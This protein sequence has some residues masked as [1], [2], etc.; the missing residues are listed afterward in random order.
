MIRKH[1]LFCARATCAIGLG[2]APLI[3]A[4]LLAGCSSDNSGDSTETQIA[5]GQARIVGLALTSESIANVNVT[6]TG[7]GL[8]SP[9]VV[10]LKKT[11]SQWDGEALKIPAATGY[12]FTLAASDTTGKTIYS[13]VAAGITVIKGQTVQVVIYGQQTTA[14]TPYS[15]AAPIVDSVV[16]SSAQVAPGGTIS[17]VATAHD[18]NSGDV[19]TYKWSAGAGTFSDASASNTSWTAPSKAGTYPLTLTVTDQQ[20]ATTSIQLQIVV[21]ADAG[22]GAIAVTAT[23]NTWPV[24]TNVSAVPNYLVKGAA[25]VLT[26]QASDADGDSLTYAWTSTCSGAFSSTQVSMPT[27]TLNSAATDSTCTLSVLVS[28]S[29][30]GTTTGSFALPVGKPFTGALPSISQALQTLTEVNATDSVT[31]SVQASDPQKLALTYAW[32]ATDGTFSSQTDTS[33]GSTITWAPPAA[34]A[35]SWSIT[36]T[37]QDSAG[38]STPYTFTVRPKSCFGTAPAATAPWKFAI[39]GDTQ[40]TATDDGKNPNSVA[41]DIINQLN[42]QFVAQGVKFVVALGDI[43][44]NGS[45]AA[46]DTRA[47]FTQALYNAGIG[48]FPLRGNHESSANAAAEFVRVFPQTRTGL[49]NATPTNAFVPHADDVNTLPVAVSGSPFTVGSS[50]SSPSTALAG[51]SYS[52]DYANSRFVLLDQFT[53]ANGSANSIPAQQSW[54]TTVLSGRPAGTHAFVFGHK[55]IITED[56]EDTLFGADPSKDPAGQDA[57]ITSLASNGVRYYM[58]GHDHMHN[59]AIVTTTD[60]VSARVQNVIVASDSSKFYTPATP[61]NDVTYNLPA[62]GHTRETPIAQELYT[63]GY[64][65][66]TINDGRAMVDYYAAAANPATGV[67]TTPLLNFN[68]RESFGYGLNGKQFVIAP[69]GSYT[70]VIDTYGGTTMQIL[71]GTNANPGVEGGNRKFSKT[72]DTAWSNAECGTAS[73]RLALSVT[74]TMGSGQTDAYALAMTYDPA[75]VN[76]AQ[77][78]NGGLGIATKDTSGNWVNAVDKNFGGTKTFVLGAYKAGYSVGTY[79]VDTTTNTA[80]AVINH[81]SDFAVTSF[82]GVGTVNGKILAINDFHG[83]ISAGKTVSGHP[84]GSAAV[85][86]SYLKSAMAGQE[87]NTVLVEAGDLIG[88]SPASSA[89]LQDEPTITFFNSFGNAN[90]ARSN[91]MDSKCNLVG[92]PGNHEFDEGVDELMR[93]LKGGNHAKGPFLENPWAGARFP[94][95]S[96]NIVKSDGT[97][98]FSPYVIKNIGGLRVAFVGATLKDTPSIVIPA[99]VTGLTFNNEADSIN[100]QVTALKAMGIHAIVAVIHNGGSQTSYAGATSSSSAAPTSDIVNLVGRLDGDVDIVITAHSHAFT[101]AYVKNAGGNLALVTQAY[102][103]G[104]GFANIDITLDPAT[105]D[106]TSKSATIVTTYADAAGLVPDPSMAALTSAAEALVGPIANTVIT[107][108]SGILTRTQ[109]SAGESPLGDMVAEAQRQ[110]VY[111]DFGITNPGGLRADLPVTCTTSPCSITWNDCFTS[112]PFGNVVMNVT[113]TGAQLYAVLEQQWAGQS[114]PK[115]LQIS[116]FGYSWSSSAPVGSKIVVGSLHKADG[117]PIDLS[118]SYT[119]AINNFLQGGGDGFTVFTGATRVVPGP[120]DLDALVGFLKGVPQPVSA[121]TDG[122]IAVLP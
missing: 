99:G 72:V 53:P 98:L 86:S 11:G 13:G 92:I 31:F 118:G 101:N 79:G 2:L 49:Q 97:L 63:V 120:V 78:S 12:K 116:G 21:A 75:A 104:T 7:G 57:F 17:V 28:D 107:S 18:P 62:F 55:G 23:F 73:A 54:L 91:L 85:V 82:P 67:A 20:N 74:G 29:K 122:R 115:M 68:K 103:A 83:Q 5:E 16:S 66:V 40:W 114:S 10:P 69:N 14:P 50:F 4:A 33:G 38:L 106:I 46:L 25:T 90:C 81:S 19:L 71:D 37:V 39:M 111:A 77:I 89:L 94:V 51:L 76:P 43:T 100:A 42:A 32:T 48:F 22:T 117:T 56:H 27:F 110:S 80:W 108:A 52:F 95:V 119:V 58:G 87:G 109:S 26:A 84:A 65:V 3:S 45:V 60:G 112:Q 96:S 35:S 113:L 105:Q 9:S 64:Y 15:N 59:R 1:H 47:E 36:V 44:D 41:V 24:V 34:A 30:G 93:L 102:S 61:P 8:K 88:A 70:S 121:A 6:V